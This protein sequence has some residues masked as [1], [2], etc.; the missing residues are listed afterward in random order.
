[1]KLK[2]FFSCLLFAF[3]AHLYSENLLSQYDAWTIV[4]S[5]VLKGDTSNI[6]V[7]V[8]NSTYEANSSI[9]TILRT[10][11]TPDFISWFFFVDDDPFTN[12]EHSCRYIF[13]NAEDGSFIVRNNTRPP[14][15]D[16]MSN[17][18]WTKI[19]SGSIINTYKSSNRATSSIPSNSATNDYAVII[20]GGSNVNINYERYWHDCSALYS[21]L[22]NN[23]GYIKNHIYVLMSDGTDP[24][25]DTK[26]L[27]G[28][29]F[30][31]PLDLDSDG[32]NDIQYAAT[33]QNIAT[34][35]N[36]LQTQMTGDDNLLIFVTDHGGFDSLN[37]N[38][39]LC[40]WDG[41]VM[42]PAEFA[43]E[44]NKINSGKINICLN[45]CYSGGFISSLQASNRVITT[46]CKFNEKSKATSNGLYDEFPFHWISALAGKT[47]YGA[48]VNADSNGDGAV[49]IKEAF[50]YAS[51]H[52]TALATETPQYSST[53]SS[54]GKYLSTNSIY[55]LL[56]CYTTGSTTQD[57]NL[58][59]PIYTSYGGLVEIYSPNIIGA[60]ITHQGVTPSY[61]LCNTSS[62][63]LKVRL[64]STGGT[65]VVQIQ[66]GNVTHYLPIIATNNSYS[67][68]INMS[69]QLMEISVESD[70]N[71]GNLEL[72]GLTTESYDLQDKEWSVEIYN[73]ITGEKVF[74][75]IVTGSS[76]TLSTTGWETGLYIVK[77]TI[78]NI[79]L[80]EKIIIKS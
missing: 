46:A 75:Q 21:T 9:R 45:Q 11:K 29:T 44:V 50:D 4:K 79:I 51:Y 3:N 70:Y 52:D 17:I 61:W 22:I 30:S 24:A 42:T 48:T 78:D 80:S 43:L 28:N 23:Y 58:P 13:V 56:G 68:S 49:S 59:Y 77:V 5:Q 69:G 8:S 20:N 37:N 74:N 34:V 6:N 10:E 38:S 2:L 76:Y 12:W 54:F 72:E 25:D 31:Q 65:I 27:A 32:T 41:E 36:T 39:F 18:V 26:G 53:P 1:M 57:I 47:P 62:G 71:R 16:D 15:F 73:A 40:L 33:K 7:Y 35:F 63:T 66:Q 19:S 64:P 14:L 55:T 67:L 60:T